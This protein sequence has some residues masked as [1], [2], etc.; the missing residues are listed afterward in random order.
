MLA[1]LFA[2][3]AS[4]KKFQNCDDCEKF[5]ELT[6]KRMDVEAFKDS[7]TTKIC[8][9]GDQKCLDTIKGIQDAVKQKYGEMTPRK[10]CEMKGMCRPKAARRILSNKMRKAQVLASYP[11]C[12]YCKNVLNYLFTDGENAATDMTYKTVNGVCED[13][14]KQ[15][16]QSMVDLCNKF[17]VHHALKLVQM[18]SGSYA[19]EQLCQA[20]GLCA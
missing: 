13:E 18:I 8:K 19:P 9:E 14:I 12:D 4:A 3:F 15:F 20:G 10:I 17:T 11:N 5:F 6:M 1:L 7:V 16:S 2:C